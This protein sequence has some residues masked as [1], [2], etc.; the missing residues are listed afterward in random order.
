MIVCKLI[1]PYPDLGVSCLGV[2]PVWGVPLL[3]I[4]GGQ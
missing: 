3:G 2:Y 4:A 1:S